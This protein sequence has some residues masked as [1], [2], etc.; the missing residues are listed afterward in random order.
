MNIKTSEQAGDDG[1]EVLRPTQYVKAARIH[2]QQ[3][4]LKKA[5]GMMLQALLHYPENALI[6][7]YYGCLQAIV[8][9][10]YRSGIEHCRKALVMFRAGDAYS[11]GIVY[12][13]LYLNLG[14]ACV[15]AGRKKD[16]LDALNKGLR[17]DKGNREIKKELLLLGVR[18][19]PPVPFLSR[20]N[21]INKY[22]GIVLHGS[23]QGTKP[24]S[25][26]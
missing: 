13:I 11:A 24:R 25:R 16:A 17:Y 9:K 22:I 8:D 15:A 14:R 12:P 6:L 1:G 2:L 5:Y 21:P 3:G 19:R 18:K 20:A 26:H 4:E 10:K 7:S 23:Q